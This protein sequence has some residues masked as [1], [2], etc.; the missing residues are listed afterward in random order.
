MELVLT[1]GTLSADE[2]EKAGLVSRVVR[3]GSVVDEAVAVAGRIGKKSQIAVQ[4]AKECVNESFNLTLTDGLRFERRL[5]QA[6]FS[7]HDQKEGMTAFAEKRKPEFK[8]Q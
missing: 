5:F 8:N 7:T 4:A 6:L 3:E 2:A 1:G